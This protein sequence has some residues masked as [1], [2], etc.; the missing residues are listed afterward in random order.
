MHVIISDSKR[1]PILRPCSV[2]P[3]RLGLTWIVVQSMPQS[4][5]KINPDPS[6][7]FCSF[8]DRLY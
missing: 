4:M 5:F 1:T 3:S 2:S 8:K 6:Q 7:I